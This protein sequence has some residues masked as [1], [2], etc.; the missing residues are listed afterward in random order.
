MRIRP[1]SPFGLHK[2]AV[3][4][5]FGQ[6]VGASL[7]DRVLGGDHHEGAA[8]FVANAVNGN[9]GF[10][11]DFQQCRLGLGRC[12]VN[13]IGEDDGGEDR[14]LMEVPVAGALIVDGDA[15]NVGGQRSGVNWIREWRALHG[16]GDRASERGLT[17]A[18]ERLPKAGGLLPSM[19]VNARRMTSSLPSSAFPTFSTMRVKASA[20]HL[21]LSGVIVIFLP[22]L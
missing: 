21:A 17:G 1:G 3:E 5:C 14:T 6:L 19:E 11:H 16:G 8:G 9:A 20:N 22:L 2:E 18:R 4:L 13:F 10:F 15:G 7:L 12:A